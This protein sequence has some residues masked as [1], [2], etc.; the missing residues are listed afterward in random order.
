MDQSNHE[1]ACLSEFAAVLVQ[2][3]AQHRSVAMRFVGTIA[4]DGEV[5]PL[6]H[7][8]QQ[9]EKMHFLRRGHFPAIA[10]HERRP[11]ARR[12]CAARTLDELAA[13]RKLREPERRTTSAPRAGPW[14][15]RAGGGARCQYAGLPGF[16]GRCRAER[17]VRPS[18]GQSVHPI[19]AGRRQATSLLA[20]TEKRPSTR[21]DATPI[22]GPMISIMSRGECG[23]G[24]D[25]I[26]AASCG[27]LAM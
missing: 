16:R 19:A 9:S 22:S 20:M 13:W 1:K 25:A 26:I 3:R 21:P 24:I 14:G 7:R 4:P 11:L 10:F 27:W 17:C 5:G 8:R 23:N 15:H 12:V 6:R 18:R 2:Q